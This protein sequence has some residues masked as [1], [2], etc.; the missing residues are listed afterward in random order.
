MPHRTII[1]CDLSAM[2]SPA[3]YEEFIM[4]ELKKTTDWLDYSI[5]H[6][7]GI[8][9]VRFLDML[10]SLPKLKQDVLAGRE[11]LRSAILIL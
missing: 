10:L 1:R 4:E 3:M 11:F 2:I 8:E 5:Y 9:Q 7:D 6:M